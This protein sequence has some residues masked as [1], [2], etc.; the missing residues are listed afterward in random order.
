MVRRAPDAEGQRVADTLKELREQA[1]LTQEE[2]A[3]RVNL[4]LSGYRTY[5][6]G[7]R[8]LRSDQVERFARAFSVP[9][10]EIVRRL[11]PPS[12]DEQALLA[13]VR[14]LIGTDEALMR[15]IVTEIRSYPTDQRAG[16][17]ARGTP[18]DAPVLRLPAPRSERSAD[19]TPGRRCS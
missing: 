11:W 5:E 10:S 7:K 2:T 14:E 8:H 6:Q 16:A 15:E 3:R 13:E 1:D 18:T 17:P 19:A 4:T 12:D 9:E